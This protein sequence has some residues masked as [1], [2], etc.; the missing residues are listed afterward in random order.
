M[1]CPAFG[2]VYTR[3][4]RQDSTREGSTHSEP[5][6]AA[7]YPFLIVLLLMSASDIVIR[8]AREHNLQDVSLTLPRNQLIVMTGV[9]GSGKSSLAF[10]TL[11]AEGQ[12]RYVE[13]LSS[14]ARQFLGQM[15]KPDVDS[16]TGLAPS[17]SI[18]QKASG[19]NP[20]STVGTIT[21]IYDYLRVL[22]ARVGTPTCY[23]CGRP[24]TAQTREHILDSVLRLP[25]GTKYQVLAPLVQRQKGEFKDLFIDLLKRGFL[26]A[27]VDGKI[28]QLTDNLQLDKQMKH[29]IEI[30]IDRLIAGKTPRARVAEAIESALNLAERKLVIACEPD[31]QALLQE[32][33]QAQSDSLPSKASAEKRSTRSTKAADAP[34]GKTTAKRSRSIPKGV[35]QDSP[36]ATDDAGTIDQLYSCDYACTHCGISYDQPSPQLFS[37]NS[38]QG[39]CPDCQGLGIRYDFATD[40]LVPDDSLTIQKGAIV[41]LGKLSSIGKW[42]KH[43]LKGVGRAI[44]IDLGMAEDSFFKTKWCDLP[45]AAKRLFLYGLGSRNITFAYRSGHGLWKH[46][47][48]YAGFIPELLD[49]YRKTRNPMRRVQLEKYMH[50]TGCASCGGSRLNPQA[51]SYRIASKSAQA[52]REER[53]TSANSAKSV[54]KNRQASAVDHQP[55]SLSLPEVCSLSTLAAWEFFGDLELSETSQFIAAE[56]LKEIRGRL[57]FLLRCGLDY[58]TLDRTA[59]T[60]SGGES[61]RI[62]LAGQIGCGLVG[63][64]YILDEPS[65]GLHPRDNVMLLD[66]LKDLR[67]QGNTVIVVEHDDETMKAADHIVDF[68]PGPGVRGGEVVVEG[69]VDEIKRAERS[70]TGAFLSGRRSIAIPKTR[71]PGSGHAIEIHGATH[72]N[73]RDVSVKFPLGQFICVTGVSGSGKSS[74]VNDILWEVLNRDI[75]KGTG[76]PGLY[77]RITGLEHIDKAIDIDQSPIG[78]TPRSNP[79]TYVK[80]FD[81]IRDLYTQLPESKMRGFKPGRFS[82]NVPGGRCEACEGNGSNKLEMDFLADIWVTCPVCQGHRF[83][84]ETLEVRFKGKNINDVLDMDIQQALEHFENHPKLIKSLQTLHDVGMDYIKLG[85]P[86]PTLSGG[87]AQ[88]VKLAK[89]LSKRSTG[90][91]VYILDEPTTGL[92]FVDIEH[93]LRVL[94]GFVEAGNTVI[95]VEHNLDVVKTADWVIDLGPE[96]GSG[97]GRILAEGTPEQIAE[98]DDSYTGR[99]LRAV[100]GLSVARNGTRKSKTS[101]AAKLQ[102]SPQLSP[103]RWQ[104]A[105]TLKGARNGAETSIVVRGAAQHNL[106]HLD[107]DIPRDRM[108]VFCGPSG[109][110]KSSLAMDTLYAEGQRRYVESLSSYARQFLGQMPKPRVEHIHGLQPSIAIEQKTVGNTPRSTVG[111]VT[112]IYDYLRI[113][114]ARLGTQY[115]PDCNKPVKA[116]TVDEVVDRLMKMGDDPEIGRQKS[117]D[118]SQQLRLM[119]LAP[120]EVTVGQQYSK[121]WERLREL[122]F[123]RVRVDGVTYSLEEVPEIDRK[124]RHQVE[125]VIDRVSVSKSGRARLAES[126]EVAFDHGKGFIRVTLVDDQRDEKKWKVLPFSLMR[127]CEQCG[128]SFEELSP[129]HFSFNSPLG[130]CSTCEGIGI[131]QGTN[132]GALIS[133]QTRSLADGAVSAWPDP[134]KSPIFR[135]MLAAMANELDIPIDLPFSQLEAE[136][137]RAVLFGTGDTWIT[138]EPSTRSGKSSKAAKA[139]SPPPGTFR[140]QYKGLYPAIEQAASLTYDYRMKLFELVGDIPCLTC[141]GSRLRDDASAVKLAGKTLKQLCDLPLRGGLEFLSQLKLTASQKKIAGDLLGEATSRL[142]FLIDV[143]LHY[144]TLARTL[145]TLSGGETQR[146]RLAGQIGRALTGVLYVLDEPTIGLHPSD[147][148]RLLSTLTQL[149]DLGNTIVMVEHDREVLLAADRLYDFGPGAGRFGGTITADGTPGDVKKNEKSLTGKYLSG[150]EEIVIPDQ[151][152]M[153]LASTTFEPKVEIVVDARPSAIKKAAKRR[154][155][156]ASEIEAATTKLDSVPSLVSKYMPPPGGGWL[157]LIGA[158][159]HNL[160]NVDLRIP[161]GTFVAVTGVSGSGKSS[162]IDDTLARAIAHKLHRASTQPG[163]YDEMNGLEFLSKLIVVD[164]QPL[165]TTPASNPATYTGVFEHIRELFA[166]MPEAKVRGYSATRFSFNRAGGRCEACEGNGQKLI[167]MHFLPDIWVECD[168]CRGQRYNAETLSVT[169][170]G[171]NIANVL[172]MSIGQ[173]LELFDNI[174]KIRAPLS[175]LAAIGLDYLT[176]GQPAPTLSGGEAQRVKLAAELARPQTGKTLYLL[177]EPTT[178]LH[179]DDIRKLLKIL[180]SLVDAGN[181]VVV[182]EHNLDVIKTADWIIDLGPHAG[183][184]GGWIV[185]EGTPEDVVATAVTRIEQGERN[186]SSRKRSA[187]AKAKNVAPQSVQQTSTLPV[188]AMATGLEIQRSLTAEILATVLDKGQRGERESFDAVATRAKRA[189][190]LDPTKIGADAKMPWETNGRKW[191]TVDGLA[192]N[193]RPRRWKG[194]I[195]AKIVDT[196]EASDE[197]APTTWNERSTVEVAAKTK[198]IGWF[199]HALTGDEWLL[200]LKFRVPKK[201]F[202][203]DELSTDLGL[204]DVNDLDHIPIYNRQPR[205]RIRPA[206]GPFEDVT[207]SI[208]EMAEVETKAFHRFLARAIESFLARANPEALNL[209]DLTPWKKL[210]RKWHMMRKGFLQGAIEWELPVLEEVESLIN[211]LLPHAVPDW[212]QKVLVNFAIEKTPVVTLVTKRPAGLDFAMIVPKGSVELGE[213]AGF[214]IDPEISAHKD[215]L[216]VVRLRFTK[217]DQ[218][219]SAALR[220]FLAGRWSQDNLK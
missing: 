158:R 62:R 50:E 143:G 155:F 29:T 30:V 203:E 97:G 17:I 34:S 159:Q 65:I 33:Y 18:Q 5:D 208:I 183:S 147:N 219:R 131:Q 168:V 150:A 148:G 137:Q 115:C 49:E 53:R 173:A 144:L 133:D 157:E 19:R 51:G 145:P 85:Q 42:R 217:V 111:T 68:G 119:I 177:D 205:V 162:L 44:E 199:L 4:A 98:C 71:R 153:R 127:S 43:I 138:V 106:Q 87:E 146:I 214:G 174:P 96:G 7:H 74:L 99:A 57:G 190:D 22:F 125:I 10:D 182:I 47:A 171:Q 11:Y 176:L 169:Y 116:Q 24:I 13:S 196:I 112:E 21:E 167:E 103:P 156:A 109:S 108:S 201:T 28:V 128:R 35:D 212:T 93:L 70:V 76:H 117:A 15:P 3:D 89:E 151:R 90:K 79:A 121:L 179:F 140:F 154:L 31:G 1:G 105:T 141:N 164:Q 64:V 193:G 6:V 132:L 136:H 175:V 135:R 210:G 67:D 139:D 59:P 60:L 81:L 126:V 113:L 118:E 75:N 194:E 2:V 100:P 27:R 186:G 91:T 202:L 39:M 209:E 180:N 178:G 77:K 52:A 23:Q 83:N 86:S 20:R 166:R 165:G 120:Q 188:M 12:R 84:K 72:H 78:R 107:L 95:V 220:A 38:P 187:G 204:K 216:E 58:L 152:R 195:L 211:Q 61:Q 192:N 36:Q 191:H 94:H 215:G 129:H 16:I 73:L 69:T 26:R 161:L 9:S 48:T 8:G 63:V 130:W 123:R 160:R 102:S 55:L 114:F 206:N 104:T 170:K 40:Q 185:A 207:L 184:E 181:T 189:G 213:V 124:R 110:G 25:D 92:H 134:A 200:T 80:L 37:F 218:V 122:G 88:R 32:E 198:A 46:G 101:K 149:R 54:S 41:V 45:D 14:Y 172:A 142:R 197:F 163:P 56:A 66:S 82:F